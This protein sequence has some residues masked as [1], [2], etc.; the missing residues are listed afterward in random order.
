MLL[1]LVELILHFLFSFEV[2][3]EIDLWLFALED[4]AA[5]TGVPS[6]ERDL[7]GDGAG[8]QH[9]EWNE[10]PEVAIVHIDRAVVDEA[11]HGRYE[12]SA[13]VL[14]TCYETVCCSHLVHLNQ[15]WDGP[16]L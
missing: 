16:K 6:Q 2:S 10:G 5:F 4:A 14:E 3:L 8:A 7:D 9:D 15:V 1:L 12:E 11:Y 13:D